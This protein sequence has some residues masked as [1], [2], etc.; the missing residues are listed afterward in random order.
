MLTCLIDHI[1]ING[2]DQPVP[3]SGLYING[4][5]GIELKMIDKVA[6]ADQVDYLGVWEDVQK[7]AAKRFLNDINAE[8]NSRY[9]LKTITQAVN[10]ERK[11]DTSITTLAGTDYRGFTL[12]LEREGQDYVSSNL[13]VINIQYLNLYLA[14]PVNTT[15]K[16]YDLDT[17]TQLFSLAVTG[18]IGWNQISVLST[19]AARRILVVYDATL[20][21]SV[22]LDITKLSN[23]VKYHND[24]YYLNYSYLNGNIEIRGALST[25]ADKYTITNAN[26]TFGLSA[27]FNI[28][29]SYEAMICNNLSVFENAFWY[30]LGIELMNERIYSSRLNEFTVMDR[31]KADDL[32]QL[33]TV[34]YKG[35][36]YKDVQY[37]GELQTAI[38]GINLNKRDICI[39]CNAPFIYADARL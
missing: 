34:M 1:G 7:R 32:H 23:A 15:V 25:I 6:D 20:V 2:C 26:D 28:Y 31:S 19:F 17:E 37:K 30:L 9:K 16:I 5:P 18:A 29:C 3:P 12:E 24:Y 10:V 38:E 33:F 35:G 14:A 27:I 36:T 22:T 11:I 13:Q 39:E 4:L 21:D 8:F